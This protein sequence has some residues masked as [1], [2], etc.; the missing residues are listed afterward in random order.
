MRLDRRLTLW[1]PRSARIRSS[2]SGTTVRLDADGV[3]LLGLTVDGS[4]GRFDL[5]DAAVRVG[6]DDVQVEGVR[7]ENAVFGLLVEQSNRALLRRNEVIGNPE[8]TLGLRGD[9]IRLWETRDS[10]IEGNQVLFSRDIVVWYSPGNHI[11]ANRVEY[12]RYGT[13][14]MYSHRNTVERN[15]YASNVV[16]IFVMYS[17]DISIRDNRILDSAGAAGLGLGAK[18]S[19]NLRVVG[20]HFIHNTVGTYLDTSPL[21]QDEWN[22][23]EGNAFRFS[24]VGV[25]FHSSPQRNSFRGN[26][27]RDNHEQVK[28]EGR[29]DALGVEW[30]ENGF[31]D[32]AGY[33]LDGDG[34]GDI[35]YELRRLSSQLTGRYPQLSF[36]RGTV[37]I[38][39]V[40]VIG[41]A[42]P[43]FRPKTLLVDPKPRL[44]PLAR[45]DE[46]AG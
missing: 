41:E 39:M 5:L 30:L 28:V 7:I 23:F 27:F 1:G 17:R 22:V 36:L 15:H 20:N 2:G 24:E 42:L 19:G 26:E 29:G 32:Y 18:E 12:G 4:G 14:F 33:D 31:D 3:Q 44:A 6:A 45:R 46:H 38:A 13:H 16:G 34:F 35:P 11:V 21:Y 37:A 40:D 9:G 43:I 10:R 25:V 8:Q